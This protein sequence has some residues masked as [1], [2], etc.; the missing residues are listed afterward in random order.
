MAFVRLGVFVG[1]SG[2]LFG[3]V[4]Q[5]L[6]LGSLLP[7]PPIFGCPIFDQQPFGHTTRK[8]SIDL[9]PGWLNFHGANIRGST[10]GNPFWQ[11]V[12]RTPP[13][14]PNE[15][16]RRHFRA[17]A[18]EHL[19]GQRQDLAPKLH[20]QQGVVAPAHRH[21]RKGPAAAP[22]FSM[23]LGFICLVCLVFCFLFFRRVG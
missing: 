8:D 16:S 4:P 21:E 13:P 11:Q 10:P 2:E 15:P 14:P 9:S 12:A 5:V 3:Y 17:P 20:V 22:L 19:P 1:S 23:F 6:V 18:E 7:G